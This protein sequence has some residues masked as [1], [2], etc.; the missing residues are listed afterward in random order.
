MLYLVWYVGFLEAQKGGISEVQ[1][2]I[3]A[4]FWVSW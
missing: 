2:S 4:L 3:P 1:N